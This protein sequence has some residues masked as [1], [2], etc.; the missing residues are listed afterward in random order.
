MVDFPLSP[1]LVKT[2][3]QSRLPTFSLSVAM[4]FF[5]FSPKK[6][7]TKKIWYRKRKDGTKERDCFQTNDTNAAPEKN[8]FKKTFVSKSRRSPEADDFIRI[9]ILGVFCRKDTQ[10]TQQDKKYRAVAQDMVREG[11]KKEE[12]KKMV[13]TSASE[14]SCSPLNGWECEIITPFTACEWVNSVMPPK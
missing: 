5:I 14:C 12:R 2:M 9:A 8:R 4:H 11:E 3:F 7:N 13:S 10:H 1:L 6:K